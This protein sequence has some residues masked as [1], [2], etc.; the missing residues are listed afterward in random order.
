MDCECPKCKTS[1]GLAECGDEWCM[2]CR[3]LYT[4]DATGRTELVWQ[5]GSSEPLAIAPVYCRYHRRAV[6]QDDHCIKWEWRD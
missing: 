1:I 5:I 6:R 3:W 2:H 4:P